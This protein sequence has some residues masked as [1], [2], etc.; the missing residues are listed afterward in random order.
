MKKQ[1]LTE[2]EI[3]RKYS[4]IVA[5][6]QDPVYG[7]DPKTLR[8][9]VMRELLII[10]YNTVEGEDM[11]DHIAY[12]LGDFFN[13]VRK[14][15]DPV[16]KKSYSGIRE[17][18]EADVDLQA[19][20]ALKSIR[21]LA[22]DPKYTPPPR[23]PMSANDQAWINN[24]VNRF[25]IELVSRG[26]STNPPPD[27]NKGKLTE[28]DPG[29]GGFGPFKVYYEQDYFIGQFSTFEEAKDEVDFRRDAD[30]KSATHHWRI[31]DG[32]G[33]TVW[34]YNIGDEIDAERRRQKFQR[35]S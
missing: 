25:T 22:G 34:E 9:Y 3:M 35:R 12:N 26:I 33:K 8:E 4:N 24:F 15:K 1:R 10:Y 30:P 20:A 28:F 32:T 19:S 18:A 5:E 27:P 11:T 31:V 29:P 17:Y 21:L 7:Q 13:A 14:S 2:S 23:P 16:L 6:A